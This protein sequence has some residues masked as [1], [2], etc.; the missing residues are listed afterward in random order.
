MNF[1]NEIK[2]LKNSN[3]KINQQE[4]IARNEKKKSKLR[5]GGNLI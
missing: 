1:L 4:L 2:D 3:K 5:N